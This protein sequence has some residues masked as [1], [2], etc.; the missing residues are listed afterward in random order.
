M[1]QG[2][3]AGGTGYRNQSLDDIREDV[4][5]WRQKSQDLKEKFKETIG[6]LRE[7]NYWDQTVPFNFRGFCNATIKTCDTVY[8]D[9]GRVLSAIDKDE[10]TKR[11]IA[12]MRNIAHIA[13]EKEL[14]AATTFKANEGHWQN[15]E[16]ENFQKAEE[17]YADG[18]DFFLT[19]LDAGNAAGRLEDY[20]KEEPVVDK[21]IHAE[22]SVVIGDG[23]QFSNSDVNVN[24]EVKESKSIG[25]W[26]MEN[27]WF[28]LL[29]VVIG[30]Y[31]TEQILKQIFK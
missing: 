23:N 22:N 31:I 19:L 17:L 2:L 25:K 8:Y 11:E 10:I 16:D 7:R 15:Y 12:I 4:D 14:Q 20:V 28:P 26:L 5:H 30:W 9:F 24:K 27:L 29:V 3:F 21:S 1:A 13:G 18:R 6:Q